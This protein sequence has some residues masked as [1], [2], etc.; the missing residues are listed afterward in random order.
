MQEAWDLLTN[1][2][3]NLVTGSTPNARPWNDTSV[4]E[5][6]A[7][8]GIVIYLVIASSSVLLE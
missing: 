8:I 1:Q 7:F 2:Y 5:M 3:A 6:K 4:E